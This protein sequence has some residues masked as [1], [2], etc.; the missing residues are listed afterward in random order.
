MAITRARLPRR[1]RTC[2]AIAPAIFRVH[3]YSLLIPRVRDLSLGQQTL[4]PLRRYGYF[5]HFAWVLREIKRL[6]SSRC[7]YVDFIC[8]N[9]DRVRSILHSV[10]LFTD[11]ISVHLP[12]FCY[13]FI[14]QIIASQS[15]SLTIGSVR[16]YTNRWDELNCIMH[17][18]FNK[19]TYIIYSLLPPLFPYFLP[20]CVK[21]WFIH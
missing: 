3:L 13:F 10:C 8:W 2:P 9:F 14:F 12:F 15:V 5:V 11:E 18:V 7:R 1:L 6:G 16:K 19:F 20:N 4:R 21:N 17:R